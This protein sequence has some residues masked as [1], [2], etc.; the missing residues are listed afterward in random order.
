M[1][2]ARAEG[3]VLMQVPRRGYRESLSCQTCRQPA[4]CT[5]CQGPLGQPRH[6]RRSRAAGGQR[7]LPVACPHCQGTELRS[8]VVGALRTAEEFARRFPDLEVVTSGGQTILDQIEPGRRLVLATPGAEPHVDGGYDVVSCSTPGSCWPARTSASRRSPIGAGSTL[9]RSPGRVHRSRGRRRPHAA[10]AR[11]RRSGRLR[12]ESWPAGPRRI[13]HPPRARDRRR[14][15][16]VLAELAT[17]TWTPHTESSDRCR[18]TCARPRRGSGSSCGRRAARAPTWLPPWRRW[19]PNAV[20][21]SC[22]AC[23]SRSIRCR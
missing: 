6:R 14:P 18:S 20:L 10:G 3:A 4:R 1:R 12:R 19:P 22:R 2:F 8:P 21:P 13:F 15:D 23:A 7:R 11:A 17:R 16:D 5:E 9:S